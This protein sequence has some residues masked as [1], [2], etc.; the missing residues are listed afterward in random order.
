MARQKDN[1][2]IY[3]AAGAAALFLFLPRA[4][5]G[6][7]SAATGGTY[8]NPSGKTRGLKNNNPGNIILTASKWDGEIDGPDGQFKAFKSP[9][10]GVKAIYT[11]LKSYYYTHN[12]K[13]LAGIITRWSETNQTEYITFVKNCMGM[14]NQTVLTEL[15]FDENTMVKLA[16]CITDFENYRGA[17]MEIGERVFRDAWKLFQ[18]QPIVFG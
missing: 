6:A 10:F 9:I 1:T 2:I 13:N 16:Q 17:S 15:K 12:L 4:G 5:A 18:G 8:P 14:Q 11:N 3:L 7:G